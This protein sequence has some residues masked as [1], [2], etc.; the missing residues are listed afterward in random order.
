MPYVQ[1]Q[2]NICYM[3][4]KKLHIG[5]AEATEAIGKHEIALNL[6]TYNLNTCTVF[7]PIMLLNL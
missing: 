6:N 1:I 7:Y 5:K 4:R 2:F 3:H